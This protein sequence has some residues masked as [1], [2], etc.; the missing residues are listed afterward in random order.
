MT[1]RV[2]Q[3][4]LRLR[5]Y[6]AGPGTYATRAE[7]NITRFAAAMGIDYDLEIVD[8]RQHPDRAATDAIVVTPTLIKLS[9]PRA[10]VF[11]DLADLRKIA[12]AFGMAPPA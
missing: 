4:R 2:S 1:N 8:L 6:I 12:I 5:L 7:Q 10:M 11:G 9:P 3:S